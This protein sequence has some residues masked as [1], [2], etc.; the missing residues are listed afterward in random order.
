MKIYEQDQNSQIPDT[1]LY[2]LLLS[3]AV[4][5][6]GDGSFGVHPIVVDILSTQGRIGQSVKGPVPGGTQ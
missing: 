1:V 6:F 2:S 4:Q 5:E 3:R